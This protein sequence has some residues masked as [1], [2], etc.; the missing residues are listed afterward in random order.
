[1]KKL[2][3]NNL[4]FGYVK[5]KN[6]IEDIS[7]SLSCP[8]ENGCII[9]LM[10]PSGSGKTT[11]LKLILGLLKPGGGKVELIP[12]DMVFSYVPQEEVLFEHLSPYDNATYFKKATAYKKRFDQNLLDEI[13]KNFNLSKVFEGKTR[14]QSLSGGEKQR[15]ELIRALSINPDILLLDEPCTGLDPEVKHAFL[16]KIRELSVKYNLLIIYVTH[17]L[18]EAK[19]ISDKIAYLVST[20]SDDIVDKVQIDT[21]EDFLKTPPSIQAV[22]MTNFPNSSLLKCNFENYQISLDPNYTNYA[23]I[24]DKNI[25]IDGDDGWEFDILTTKGLYVHLLHSESDNNITLKKEL[26]NPTKSKVKI[27]IKGDCAIYNK[28]GIFEKFANL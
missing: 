12:Q 23:L 16:L 25:V 3:I 22:R 10:G 13:I 17:H 2:E 28:N 8:E 1:M 18:D 6:L 15:L 7:F 4:S 5:G 11:L 19:L 9:S 21:V 26:I 20:K 24:N 27:K 14:V